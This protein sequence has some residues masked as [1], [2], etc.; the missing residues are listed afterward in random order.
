MLIGLCT[1]SA[2]AY[3]ST[4]CFLTW[5]VCMHAKLPQLC[6]TLWDLVD[7]NPPGSSVDG[8]SPG[9]KTGVGCQVLLQGIFL[10]QGWN[11][12]LLWPLHWHAGSLPLAPPGT[13]VTFFLQLLGNI[14]KV[15]T[16]IIMQPRISLERMNAISDYWKMTLFVQRKHKMENIHVFHLLYFCMLLC[17][18][19]AQGR[20]L[21]HGCAAGVADRDLLT[22]QQRCQGKLKRIKMHPVTL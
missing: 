7:H 5:R 6:P 21:P 18:W 9:K 13:G 11:P 2:S 22:L 12:R 4:S 16:Y 1:R 8:E 14:T 10:T 19:S 20:H 15:T 3:L 17:P